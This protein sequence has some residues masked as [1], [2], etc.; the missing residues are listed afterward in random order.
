MPYRR[1]LGS[2][3]A[4]L[5]ILKISMTFSFWESFLNFSSFEAT[6]SEISSSEIP[7]SAQRASISSSSNSSKRFI[8]TC[9]SYSFNCSAYV[10][11]FVATLKKYCP[12]QM[13]NTT[14][15]TAVTAWPATRGSKPPASKAFSKA[16]APTV[17]TIVATI[18]PPRVFQRSKNLSASLA[19]FVLSASATLDW[20]L[21]A[22]TGRRA[23][24]NPTRNPPDEDGGGLRRAM[25]AGL[26]ANPA[27]GAAA[28]I[29][30]SAAAT[31]PETPSKAR[32][33]A[34]PG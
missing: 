9:S 20:S 29:N 16:K 22:S 6:V 23:G 18:E 24:A 10:V 27:A 11:D 4:M 26:A 3:D 12:V 33:S 31:A 5:W 15:Y 32:A 13:I 28:P 17:A 1:A 34:R 8:I 14:E 30:A 2:S 25:A 21:V 19:P 7:T